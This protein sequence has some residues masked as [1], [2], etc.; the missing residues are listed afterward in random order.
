MTVVHI[1]LTDCDNIQPIQDWLDNN[2]TVTIDRILVSGFHFYIFY[3][4]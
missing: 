1:E 4:E 3:T 2:S